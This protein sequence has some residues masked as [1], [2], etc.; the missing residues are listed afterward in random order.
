[1][2]FFEN[3]RN[4]FQIENYNRSIF[5]I[6]FYYESSGLVDCN[7]LAKYNLENNTIIKYR[8]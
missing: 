4:T 2:Q 5:L 7:L 3:C 8:N 6:I 1:M